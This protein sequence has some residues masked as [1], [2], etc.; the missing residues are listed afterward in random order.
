MSKPTKEQQAILDNDKKNLIVSA[1]AGSGKTFIVVEYIINLIV[2][3]HIPVSRLLV[4]TF[5]KA[6]ANEMKNRLFKE[7]L[8][9]KNTPFLLEQLDDISI[10]DISTIDAFCEKIIKRYINKLDIDENFRVLD[11][12]ECKNLKFSAFNQMF[13]EYSQG[14]EYFNEIYFAFKHDKKELFECMDYLQNYFDCQSDGEEMLNSYIE[15]FDKYY[16]DSLVYLNSILE[17]I[18]FRAKE[19]LKEIE[20]SDLSQPFQ[21][22]YIN[23]KNIT[24]IQLKADFFENCEVINNIVFPAVPRK[25][26]ELVEEKTKITMARDTLKEMLK[27]TSDFKDITLTDK[28]SLAKGTLAKGLLNMVRDYNKKYNDMKNIVDGLDFAD[29][30]RLTKQLLNDNQILE[31]LQKSYDYIFIDEYQDTNILQESII[32]PISEKGYFVAV[33]DIKQGIYGFRNASMEIMQK[34]IKNFSE[35]QDSQA[36]FLTGNFRS[37][38]RV[39]DFINIVFNKIMT[40]ESVGID[41][42]GKNQLKGLMNF[43]KTS[44]PSVSVDLII[45]EDKEVFVPTKIYSVK[46]DD[47]DNS[48]KYKYEVYTLAHRIEEILQC[49]IYDAKKEQF[50]KVVP[51]DIAILY[52]SRDK[53]MKEAVRFLQEKG[54]PVFADLKQDLTNDGQVQIL[55][56]LIKISINF[57][58][59]ISLISVLGSRFGGFTFEELANMRIA[60]PKMYFWEIIDNDSSEKTLKF[61]EILQNFKFDCQ[62]LGLT[63]AFD[64]LF[65]LTNYNLYIG[66]LPDKN[67]KFFHLQEFFKLIS[68]NNFDYNPSAL[69][70]YID[71]LDSSSSTLSTSTN[72]IT[73][74]TIHATKGLEYP[75]VIL[76]GAG[77]KLSKVYKKPYIISSNFG[78]GTYLYNYRDNLRL[79][80]PPFLAGRYYKKRRE[81]ID[82]LMIFYVALTRAQNHL[83]IIGTT[84]EE[85]LSQVK[86]LYACDSYLDFLLY[87]HGENFQKQLLGQM[88]IKTENYRYSII[89]KVEEID[90]SHVQEEQD[91]NITLTQNSD[92]IKKYIDFKYKDS[93][94]CKINYKNS[95][96]GIL[97]LENDIVPKFEY[98]W[99]DNSRQLAINRGNAYHQALKYID[100]E[101]ISDEKSLHE[102]LIAIKDFLDD[103]YYDLIDESLLLKDIMLLK[104][105]VK[106]KVYKEREFIMSAKLNEVLNID[107]DNDIIIQG[108]IDLFSLGEK[109]ILIDYKYSSIKDEKKL[110]HH[111][112][113]QLDLYA[114]A[115]EKAFDIELDEI[116]L[117]SL[118][119]A[120]LIAYQRK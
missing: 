32:K 96:S 62:T 1:S 45:K 64:K 61:K 99:N 65:N 82:E 33:G 110:L 37:D 26:T 10:S 38:K 89:D 46:E 13:D 60:N 53:A 98:Q 30:E 50:R 9:Q 12:K 2:N 59:D 117:L 56:S 63:K 25:K 80:S 51:S 22:F 72:A 100:F 66:G 90:Y 31:N 85:N 42:M 21:E 44:L 35:S 71:N 111:Y 74:T 24:E 83:Y 69:I 18:L 73:I 119:N 84:T 57:K 67:T 28:E 20:Y 29:L 34:D 27:I 97:N 19:N 36:L 70:S 86:D 112:Q 14:G 81:F 17:S 3:H 15:K 16:A 7:I 75:I 55:L 47:I 120:K 6:A 23:V 101:S 8:N 54:F 116:Y 4:L 40:N 41:Y 92:E 87:S 58:D 49:Q 118:G 43:E 105:V 68:Q 39:L 11:E 115:I 113:K 88:E 91:F 95:V 106:G 114:T 76:A 48:Y 108:I 109:N 107:S 93:S 94:F 102:S 103:G 77:E 52:R 79:V 78:L 104:N 5:T